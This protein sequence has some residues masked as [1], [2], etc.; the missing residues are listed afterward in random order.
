MRYQ[1][2]VETAAPRSG[3]DQGM[4][5]A[6]VGYALLLGIGM[7]AVG[8]RARQHWLAFWGASLVVASAAFLLAA[9][10]GAAS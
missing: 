3:V 8:R 10:V 7:V 1:E 4:L 9:A 5:V 2:S 6:T